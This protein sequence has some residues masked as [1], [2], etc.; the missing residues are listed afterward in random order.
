[1]HH[2]IKT[3][4]DELDRTMSLLDKHAEM[5]AQTAAIIGA[6]SLQHCAHYVTVV[7]HMRTDSIEEVGEMTAALATAG[8]IGGGDTMGW[9]GARQVNAHFKH[10]KDS[11][12]T[13]MLVITEATPGSLFAEEDGKLRWL[14]F[15]ES[16]ALRQ[17]ELATA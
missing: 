10:E 11:S 12:L 15:D 9:N 17:P 2:L 6:D 16:D 13:A 5:I 14:R 4:Y 3:V 8:F 7:G 1:M